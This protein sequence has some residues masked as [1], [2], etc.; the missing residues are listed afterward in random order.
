MSA[1]YRGRGTSPLPSP[2]PPFSLTP[3]LPLY[4]GGEPE[5]GRKV[6]YTPLSLLKVGYPVWCHRRYLAGAL[7]SVWHQPARL[8]TGLE[9]HLCLSVCP[10]SGASFKT[11]SPY[12]AHLV[13][14]PLDH[15]LLPLTSRLVHQEGCLSRLLWCLGPATPRRDSRT[16]LVYDRDEAVFVTS[17]KPQ[18]LPLHQVHYAPSIVASQGKWYSGSAVTTGSSVGCP[19]VFSPL[20]LL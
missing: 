11:R 16:L 14:W 10:Q 9:F 2:R 15:L 1:T 7:I 12:Q 5:R 18:F 4:P 8:G 6:R 17:G 19:R 3:T 13:Q 20:C